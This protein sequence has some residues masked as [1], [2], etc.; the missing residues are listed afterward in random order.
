MS[1]LVLILVILLMLTGLIGTIVPFIPGIPL[2]YLGYVLY[3][4]KSGWIHYSTQTMVIWG[5]IT[6][7]SVFLDYYSGALGAKKYGASRIGIWGSILGAI[8]GIIFLGFP[9]IIF[10]PFLGA[11]IG[12]FLAGKN[13]RQALRAGWGSFIGFLAG[14]FFKIVLAITMIGV[15]LW[16]IIIT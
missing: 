4:F 1:T 11:I 5:L 9:G 6:L 2:I 12:E 8:F 10:G 13:S 16:Q 15:F 7:F 3:G 14:S